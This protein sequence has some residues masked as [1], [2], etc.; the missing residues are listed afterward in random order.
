MTLNTIQAR[1]ISINEKIDDLKDLI[2]LYQ[3]HLADLKK[4]LSELRNEIL[5]IT[6]DLLMRNTQKQEDNIFGIAWQ[7]KLKNYSS[8]V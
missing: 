8:Q 6:L 4:E 7:S 2:S 1:L 3:E 5:A